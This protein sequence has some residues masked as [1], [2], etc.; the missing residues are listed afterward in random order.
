MLN[1]IT[2]KFSPSFASSSFC[3]T[4]KLRIGKKTSLAFPYL[5]NGIDAKESPT[6]RKR[7]FKSVYS[8]FQGAK[9]KG[10]RGKKEQLLNPFVSDE[11][12]YELSA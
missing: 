10:D 1:P 8:I 2:V 7:G 9:G 6:N 5:W 12:E 11:Y 4:F 3:A